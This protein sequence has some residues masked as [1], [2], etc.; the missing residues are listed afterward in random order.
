MAEKP[1]DKA[2]AG[3]G[4]GGGSSF[5]GTSHGIVWGLV[6]LVILFTGVRTSIVNNNTKIANQKNM[7]SQNLVTIDTNMGRIVF[8]TYDQDA[9][10]ASTNFMKL[11]KAGF[12]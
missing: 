11:A 1:K 6:G 2:K 8:E 3:S 10:V 7:P 9:P 4:G 5:S 12:Y